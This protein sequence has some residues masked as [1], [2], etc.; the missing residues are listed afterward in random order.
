MASWRADPRIDTRRASYGRTQRGIVSPNFAGL[1]SALLY[2][3]ALLT[4]RRVAL[5][6]A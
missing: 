2:E 3:R 1:R 6:P 5:Q 4:S